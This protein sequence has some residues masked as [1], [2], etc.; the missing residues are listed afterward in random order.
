[1]EWVKGH[2]RFARDHHP[3][4]VLEGI[5]ALVIALTTVLTI[6]SLAGGWR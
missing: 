3:E 1:M 6:G 2:I 5:G 4:L